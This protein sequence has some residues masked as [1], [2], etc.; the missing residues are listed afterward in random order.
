MSTRLS[1][2]EQRPAAGPARERLPEPARPGSEIAEIAEMEPASLQSLQGTLG[3]QAVLRRL[4]PGRPLDAGARQ[5]MEGVL[6]SDFSR[7]RVHTGAEGAMLAGRFQARAVTVGEDIAFAPGEYQPGTPLGDAILAHELAHV[8][9]QQ[10]APEKP[11]AAEAI[12]APNSPLEREA[13]GAAVGAVAAL[14][15]ADRQGAQ[16]LAGRARPTLKSQRQ[17]QRCGYTVSHPPHTFRSCG[18]T[19]L[20]GGPLKIQ[21]LP[22]ARPNQVQI[23]SMPYGASGEVKISG[24]TDDQARE[25]KTGFLQTVQSSLRRFIYFNAAGARQASLV[26]SVPSPTR[27]EVPLPPDLPWYNPNEVRQFKGTD[28]SQRVE[29]SDAPQ[30]EIPWKTPDGQGSLE[31][32]EGKDSFC[33][34][35]VA[36]HRSGDLVF[37]NWATWSVDWTAEYNPQSRTGL[38]TGDGTRTNDSG[39]GRGNLQ[40]VQGGNSAAQVG[41]SNIRWEA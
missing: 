26:T 25:W 29:L 33:L 35:M 34:W 17:L 3:N 22:R 15:A 40:P 4:G 18:F 2:N 13:E 39:E 24:G 30:W 12:D 16:P 31:K 14:W 38:G 28:D 5:R 1:P 20:G 23:A 21:D 41:R 10:G 11:I 6:R 27:D 19:T 7:V 32:S 37:L 36:R 8:V 9:Q